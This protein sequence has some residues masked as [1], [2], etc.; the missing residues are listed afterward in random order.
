ML[1]RTAVLHG[2][3]CGCVHDRPA[4]GAR[5]VRLPPRSGR[6]CAR[7]AS[8]VATQRRAAC[9]RSLLL[10]SRR[11]VQA[12]L[13]YPLVCRTVRFFCRFASRTRLFV[14]CPVCRSF[15][16]CGLLRFFLLREWG[17]GGVNAYSFETVYELGFDSRQMR[18]GFRLHTS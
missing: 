6:A 7:P 17:R 11:D 5:R 10:R 8:R 4:H 14:P 15:F 9:F 1:L 3:H 16:A 12:R 18:G 2:R 13:R